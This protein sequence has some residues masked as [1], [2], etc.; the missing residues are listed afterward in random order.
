MLAE[1]VMISSC[2]L[3]LFPQYHLKPGLR[4]SNIDEN[5]ISCY[6]DQ[7]RALTILIR[8]LKTINKR[9]ILGLRKRFSFIT[10]ELSHLANKNTRYWANSNR[11]ESFWAFLTRK[12]IIFPFLDTLLDIVLEYDEFWVLLL[13]LQILSNKLEMLGKVSGN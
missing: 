1:T 8:F 11:N 4:G 9:C 7:K 3:F 10:R 13:T 2:L 12:T 6:L 5:L